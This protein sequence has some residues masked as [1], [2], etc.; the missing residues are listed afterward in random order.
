MSTTESDEW[1]RLKRRRHEAEWR[2]EWRV[3]ILAERKRLLPL[4]RSGD[5]KSQLE[6]AE[7][8]DFQTPKNVR[9]AQLWYRRAAAGGQ[10]GAQNSLG[11]YILDEVRSGRLPKSARKEAVEWFRKAAEQGDRSAQVSLGYSLFYGEGVRRNQAEAYRWYRRAARQGCERASLNLARMHRRGDHVV[12]SRP[13]A[14][15]WARRA[16]RLGNENAYE[17]LYYLW[18]D[19]P[20][21]PKVA[22]RWLMEGVRAGDVRCLCHY[23]DLLRTGRGVKRDPVAAF[24][25]YRIASKH[26]AWARYMMARCYWRGWGVTQ[27]RRQAR[28]WFRVAAKDGVTEAARMLVRL[29]AESSP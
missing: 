16:L 20:A 2:R 5:L 12:K 8:L 28:T 17:W 26:S 15:W 9:R 7:S 19:A 24:E 18:L 22:R 3:E 1:E 13:R 25:Q 11:E 27:N 29:S 4:A 23:G 21:N 6:L 10:A 14:A